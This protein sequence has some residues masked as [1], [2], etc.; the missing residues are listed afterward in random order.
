MY[1]RRQHIAALGCDVDAH[2]YTTVFGP[3]SR[4]RKLYVAPVEWDTGVLTVT[5]TLF[6]KKLSSIR[7]ELAVAQG[8][9]PR[10][11]STTRQKIL[12]ILQIKIPG[13][14]ANTVI[15]QRVIE[16][17]ERLPAVYEECMQ[18]AENEVGRSPSL[19][20]ALASCALQTQ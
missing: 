14:R 2:F 3:S 8:S 15:G 5:A 17:V 7:T 16:Y 19:D 13:F 1:H 6:H 4:E 18:L 20:E 12:N 10:L 11:D 9:I